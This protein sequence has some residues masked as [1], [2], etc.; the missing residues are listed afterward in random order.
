MMEEKN[1]KE[2]IRTVRVKL[3]QDLWSDI[4]AAANDLTDKTEITQ[5]DLVEYILRKWIS[6]HW[7]SRVKPLEEKR[8]ILKFVKEGSHDGS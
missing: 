8:N 4:K 3:P 5:H 7:E 1:D 6:E 2:R